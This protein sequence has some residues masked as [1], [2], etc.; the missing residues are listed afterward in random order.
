[1]GLYGYRSYGGKLYY[2]GLLPNMLEMI[3][4]QYGKF[5]EP[6]STEE[7]QRILNT[8]M[9]SGKLKV[10]GM[11]LTFQVFPGSRSEQVGQCQS[12]DQRSLKFVKNINLFMSAEFSSA[13][14]TQV[15]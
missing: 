9:K 6:A 11:K 3:R 7:W 10:K 15:R 4:V 12:T 5:D 1:M 8:H 14:G 2:Y 13:P